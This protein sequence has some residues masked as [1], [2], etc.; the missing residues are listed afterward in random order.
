MEK[1]ACGIFSNLILINS[2]CLVYL[3]KSIQ[4]P[5]KI[6]VSFLPLNLLCFVP[7]WECFFVF[8]YKLISFADLIIIQNVKQFH[9]CSPQKLGQPVKL[10]EELFIETEV[11]GKYVS[12]L[13]E[14]NVIARKEYGHLP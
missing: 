7:I 9:L 8:Q 6:Q 2:K 11:F 1:C 13:L 4:N 5:S 12:F 10:G 14:E 3:V